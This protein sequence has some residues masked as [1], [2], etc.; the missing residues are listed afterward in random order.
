M[1]VSIQIRISNSV[2]KDEWK[3]VYEESLQL[4]KVFPLGEMRYVECRGIE[5]LC[6]VPTEERIGTSGSNIGKKYWKADGDYINLHTAEEYV[7][8]EDMFRENEA[9]S[10]DEDVLLGFASMYLDGEKYDIWEQNSFS[11]WGNKTQGETYHIY[12]LAV[13]CL[14][15]FRLG[16]KALVYGDI[17]RGQCK[18]AVELANK[19]LSNP[20]DIPDRCNMERLRVRMSNLPIGE[21]EQ[22]ILFDEMYLGTKDAE[23]GEYLRNSYLAGICEEYWRDRFGAYKIGT[24]GFDEI[25]KKY[26]LWG[27]D[28]RKL[29]TLVNY[30]G[31]NNDQ[32]KKFVRRINHIIYSWYER[33]K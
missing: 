31:G 15:E 10:E 29:C 20:I 17:T 8:Y 22:M 33:G 13:A 4:V 2:T 24:L 16:K 7:L 28:L 1:G 3:K 32:Y 14:I 11:I 5:T 9:D 12:L 30:D 23:Y 18:K 6:L 21:K 26:L 27:F 25:I 19:C